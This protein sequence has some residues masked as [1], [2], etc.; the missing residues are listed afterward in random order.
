MTSPDF[1]TFIDSLIPGHQAWLSV[2]LI[3]TGRQFFDHYIGDDLH[4]GGLLRQYEVWRMEHGYTQV[5]PWNGTEALGR[6]P[7][8]GMLYV[9]SQLL[10]QAKFMMMPLHRTASVSG[11]L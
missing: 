8:T 3:P 4:T 6:V 9:I 1:C 5:R 11:G 7:D 10:V 2:N